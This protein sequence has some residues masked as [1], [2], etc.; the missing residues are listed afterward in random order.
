MTEAEVKNIVYEVLKEELDE[1]KQMLIDRRVAN[2]IQ[3][4][5]L[6]FHEGMLHEISRKVD[7]MSQ[8]IADLRAEIER[9]DKRLSKWIAGTILSV[10]AT[11]VGI[12]SL[13]PVR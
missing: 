10:V 4:Q 9:R 12:L 2:G 3:D 7:E 5:K 6:E 8:N 13:V 11:F 1:L